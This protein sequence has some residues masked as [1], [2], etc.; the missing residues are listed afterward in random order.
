MYLF[1]ML[2]AGEY[3]GLTG[4][5]L[6]GAEMLACSLATHFVPSAKL[7]LLE[8]ELRKTAPT[9]PVNISKIIYKYEEQPALKENSA[10]VQL[11]RI[12]KFDKA[13][14]KRSI[15]ALLGCRATFID[16]DRNPKWEPCR[17]E[18]VS[19]SMVDHCFS[20]VDD[21]EWQDLKFPVRSKLPISRL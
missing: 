13:D 15:N 3:L 5:R 9:D 10:Y 14:F 17:L 1:I 21:R 12:D 4:A 2:Y 18:L 8:E 16:K 6:D 11:R 19:D 20:R 7:P